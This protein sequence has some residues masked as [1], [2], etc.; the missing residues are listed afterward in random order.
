VA[1]IC[2]YPGI[3][4]TAMQTAIREQPADTVGAGV[5]QLFQEFYSSG[6]LQTPDRP[7]RLIAALAGAAGAAYNGQIVDIYSDEAQQLLD[8]H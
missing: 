7:A 2:V 4:D 6:R 8:Q 1:A 3:V 5:R